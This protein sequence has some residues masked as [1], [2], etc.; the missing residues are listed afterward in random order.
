MKIFAVQTQINVC[1]CQTFSR[2]TSWDIL[3]KGLFSSRFQAYRLKN[4]TF[5]CDL[6]VILNLE[7]ALEY[8]QHMDTSIVVIKQVLILKIC[9][10]KLTFHCQYY[11]KTCIIFLHGNS[12]ILSVCIYW[13]EI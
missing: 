7:I 11:K 12:T 10:L 3:S 1:F 5:Y 4:K 13:M 2:N 9:L 6:S 8:Q